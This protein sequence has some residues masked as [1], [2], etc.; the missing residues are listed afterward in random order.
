MPTRRVLDSTGQLFPPGTG[1]PQVPAGLQMI[2]QSMGGGGGRG[3]PPTEVMPPAGGGGKGGK[4]GGAGIAGLLGAGGGAGGAAGGVAAKAGGAAA[5]EGGL[6]GLMKMLGGGKGIAGGGIGILLGLLLGSLLKETV[7]GPQQMQ[8]Q[9]DLAL[10]GQP[11]PELIAQQAMAPQ[12][13]SQNDLLFMT[14]M[15]QMG[16]SGGITPQE[17]AL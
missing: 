6:A 4:G 9:A 5:A 3:I 11:P 2:L 15:Q 14:L 12:M 13:Q 17:M 10:S 8:T 16:G 7:T 1:H